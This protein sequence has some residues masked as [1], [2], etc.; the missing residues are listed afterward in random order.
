MWSLSV[1][2]REIGILS[3]CGLYKDIGIKSVEIYEVLKLLVLNKKETPQHFIAFFNAYFNACS[4]PHKGRN[5]WLERLHKVI[6]ESI[7]LEN[8]IIND[9]TSYVL[10]L[11][12][13]S[14]AGKFPVKIIMQLS[15]KV[16][17]KHLGYC[18]GYLS[19]FSNTQP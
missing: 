19:D 6:N 2:H 12:P 8:K 4:D 7:I 11:Q 13:P 18:N 1:C 15:G 3:S 14:P 17:M 16:K 10:I 9:N 5:Q